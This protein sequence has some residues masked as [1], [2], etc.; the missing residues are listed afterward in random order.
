LAAAVPL[1]ALAASLFE[2]AWQ[3]FLGAQE[4]TI[5]RNEIIRMYLAVVVHAWSE[6]NS[7]VLNGL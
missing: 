3:F 2:N 4:L 7:V 1:A 6:F 5:H